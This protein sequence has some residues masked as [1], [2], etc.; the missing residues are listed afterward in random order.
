MSPYL[1]SCISPRSLSPSFLASKSKTTPAHVTEAKAV[2]CCSPT[3]CLL[4]GPPAVPI[5]QGLSCLHLST[6]FPSPLSSTNTEPE[7]TIAAPQHEQWPDPHLYR[8][9]QYASVGNAWLKAHSGAGQTWANPSPAAT[10]CILL[11]MPSLYSWNLHFLI[12]KM[13]AIIASTL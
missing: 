12:C 10:C 6:C 11:G 4:L 5:P 1:H 13:R 3:P 8:S 2:W 9:R 7:L